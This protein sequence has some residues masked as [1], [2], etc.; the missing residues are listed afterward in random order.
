MTRARWLLLGII[1]LTGCQGGGFDLG[2]LFQ[3][4]PPPLEPTSV[5]VTRI[6]EAAG[7]TKREK[8]KL[9]FQ[10][11][12]SH[13]VG[14][15]GEPYPVTL[16]DE[17]WEMVRAALRD[18]PWRREAFRERRDDAEASTSLRFRL[19]AGSKQGPDADVTWGRLKGERLPEGLRE[20]EEAFITARQLVFGPD[21]MVDLL[22]DGGRI[23][24]EA[25]IA[26]L[27]RRLRARASETTPPATAPAER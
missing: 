2:G 14:P 3:Q 13:F 26:E 12:R 18:R 11:D 8:L 10:A 5:T 21:D 22:G 27:M 19:E 4:A 6:V 7:E 9:D 20:L 1:A 25:G 16:P 15:A 23:D 24:S 17:Q